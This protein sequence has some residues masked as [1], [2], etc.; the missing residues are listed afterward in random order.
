[1]PEVR[2]C[3]VVARN[4]DPEGARLMAYVVP[5]GDAAL[6]SGE[7]RR[8]LQAELPDYMV[9]NLFVVLDALPLTAAG[10]VD[11]EKLPAPGVQRPA[12]DE[13][14]VAP[15]SELE[16]TIGRVWREVL[17][18]ERVGVHD[19]FFDLGG[20]SLL[21]VRA[22]RRI[23]TALRVS[24]PLVELFRHPTVHAL[25][26]YVARLRT[27]PSGADAGIAPESLSQLG[28]RA[29]RQ[30]EARARRRARMT[31]GEAEP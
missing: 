28:D 29:E 10:K 22:H 19:N 14:F 18:L 2:A 27:T 24:V 7:L 1:M 13:A 11:R 12:L 6:T 8:Q 25:S 3:V 20:H 26:A 15:A 5:A 9:P 23:E 17:G 31:L 21:M 16:G 30:R 4:A